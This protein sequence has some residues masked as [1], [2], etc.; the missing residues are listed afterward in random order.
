[1]NNEFDTLN[2]LHNSF[3]L[4]IPQP[5]YFSVN[6][7]NLF[8]GYKKIAGI[9]LSRCISE[10]PEKKIKMVAQDI[11]DFL[12]IL[13]SGKIKEKLNREKKKALRH[14][15]LDE[16]RRFW[17]ENYIKTKKIIFPII[18]NHQKSWL[19]N[20]FLDFL[21]DDEN[22][23][24]EPTVTHCDFDTSN[25]LIDPKSFKLNAIIDFEEIRLWDPAAD[26]LFYN[27]GTEFVNQIIIRYKNKINTSFRNRMR[28][29]FCRTC[30]PYMEF[31]LE[32]NLPKMVEAGREIL[33]N[34]ME[35][36]PNL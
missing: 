6:P 31:G 1:M 3:N 5:K 2:I 28:F 15:T 21:N 32:N 27:E 10:I 26:F 25:I 8:I 29:L 9:S 7:K 23:S 24:F 4:Q 12:S 33:N 14:F 30:V 13:H 17:E 34:N 18:K 36:F 11:A 35:I 16:Y 19:D 22:F 20:V